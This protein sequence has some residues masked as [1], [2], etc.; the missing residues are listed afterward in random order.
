M[1]G[2]WLMWGTLELAAAALAIIPRR[3]L[4]PRV[5]ERVQ[6]RSVLILN[7]EALTEFENELTAE[8]YEVVIRGNRSTGIRY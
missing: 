3:R 5:A 1:G 6:R 7:G 2:H 8:K 4:P